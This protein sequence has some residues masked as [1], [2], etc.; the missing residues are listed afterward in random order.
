MD[1][2]LEP[3]A[4]SK[5]NFFTEAMCLIN[6][7]IVYRGKKMGPVDSEYTITMIQ[8]TS[9]SLNTEWPASC[10]HH[11]PYG[12]LCQVPGGPNKVAEG[13]PHPNCRVIRTYDVQNR[14]CS[15]VYENVEPHKICTG[16]EEGL[17]VC[18]SSSESVLHIVPEGCKYLFR[19]QLKVD[20]L[21]VQ[22]MCYCEHRDTLVF[23]KADDHMIF[24]INLETGQKMWEISHT[25]EDIELRPEDICN[26][27]EI[28]IC[29]ANRTN[30][31]F[32]VP[33]HGNLS[34]VGNMDKMF[35]RA[36]FDSRAQPQD[37]PGLSAD[38]DRDAEWLK[39][40]PLT[41]TLP[42][43][44]TKLN[45]F[46]EEWPRPNVKVSMASQGSRTLVPGVQLYQMGLA[47]SDIPMTSQG[48]HKVM[49]CGSDMGPVL[50]VRHNEGTIITCCDVLPHAHHLILMFDSEGETE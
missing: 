37:T 40:P 26:I 25:I 9:G 39:V 28:W 7:C 19:H 23:L 30:L 5:L 32:L 49:Y 3:S 47:Q 21:P 24:A 33:C 10:N 43:S 27:G 45:L 35:Q 6:G 34:A 38:A 11:L 46:G 17:L 2:L 44:G 48:P 12:L 29:V 31:L 16:P 41:T 18:D 14:N 8:M 50:A 36:K 22:G 1:P 15:V 4:K 42:V 13:C 20:F